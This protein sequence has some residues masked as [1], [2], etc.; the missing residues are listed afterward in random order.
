MLVRSTK[1][2]KRQKKAFQDAY[3]PFQKN[4][5]KGVEKGHDFEDFSQDLYSSLYQVSPDFD[6]VHD[7]PG[8]QIYKNALSEMS[9]LPEYANLRQLGTTCDSFQSG[10]GASILTEH[11]AEAFPKVEKPNPDELEKQQKQLQTLLEDLPENSGSRNRFGQQLRDVQEQHGEAVTRWQ[12]AADGI[13]NAML[14]QV[15][16]RGLIEA[17]EAIQEADQAT[18]AFGVGTDPG[19]SAYS[20]PSD[21]LAIARALRE[22]PKLQEI[23]KLAGRFKREAVYKQANKKHP[24]PDEVADIEMGND[25]GRLIPAE[26]MKLKNPQTRLDFFR[27]YLE[28]GLVQYKLE[29]PEE[30]QRGPIILCLDSSGSMATRLGKY[31]AE[32]W[33]KAVMLAMAQ[34]A[35]SQKRVLGVYHFAEDVVKAQQ[36]S[37]PNPKDLYE[38]SAY[39]A[40]GSGTNFVKPLKKAFQ[41]IRENKNLKKADIVFITDGLARIDAV[42]LDTFKKIEEETDA[43]VY[44]IC[45]GPGTINLH[46]LGPVHTIQEFTEGSDDEIKDVLFSI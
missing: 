36:Y 39:F 15:L 5:D 2:E 34:I 19:T 27:K 41:E 30:E 33:S 43:T 14:R 42:S 18:E 37:S 24:G 1:W 4:I 13:D 12:E 3:N 40:N 20:N 35:V 31:T 23:A 11:F 6:N 38:E 29:T 7:T 25:L 45:I 28:G 16:R 8:T 22:N 10:L 44:S 21:K 46:E 32:V 17:Q 9:K 26:L